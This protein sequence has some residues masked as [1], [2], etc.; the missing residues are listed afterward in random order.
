MNVAVLMDYGIDYQK[1]LAQFVG[2][3]AIYEKY[4]AQFPDD[5]HFKDALEAFGR[6]DM[7][8][9]LRQIHALKGLASTL[10]FTELF[11][12]CSSAVAWLRDKSPD[13]DINEFTCILSNMQEIY[14]KAKTGCRL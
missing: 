2:N 12:V 6:D 8:G 5:E 7:D 3:R 4:L 10:G 9:S 14:E 1:G 11:E 13:K